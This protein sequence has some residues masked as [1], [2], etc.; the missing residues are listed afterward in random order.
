MKE[1]IKVLNETRKAN[2]MEFYGSIAVII[3]AFFIFK[4]SVI[5]FA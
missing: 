4:F 3:T 5:I 1:M 2:P